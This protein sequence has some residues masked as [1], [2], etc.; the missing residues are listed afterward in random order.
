MKR[1]VRSLSFAMKNSVNRACSIGGKLYR[2]DSEIDYAPAGYTGKKLPTRENIP[3]KLASLRACSFEA[4]KRLFR[5]DG[6]TI[7]FR[8]PDRYRSATLD[9]TTTMRR[10]RSATRTIGQA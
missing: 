10:P 4:S 5:D 7:E 9:A 1:L 8:P 3:W 2:H 6:S